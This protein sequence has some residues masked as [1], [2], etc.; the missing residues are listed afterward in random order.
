MSQL[1]FELR[2]SLFRFGLVV[3]LFIALS[4][5]FSNY[6]AGLGMGLAMMVVL[7]LLYV[8]HDRNPIQQCAQ[9]DQKLWSLQFKD[10]STVQEQL[11]RVQGFGPCV[12]LKFIDTEHNKSRQLCICKDQIPPP[13]WQQLQTLV[14]LFH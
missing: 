1:H 13:Q 10:G 3:G 11:S 12:F 5:I 6:L 8:F 7:L 2:P 14:K 4:M 9:L